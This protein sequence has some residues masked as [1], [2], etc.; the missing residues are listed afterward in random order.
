MLEKSE[1]AKR[2][3]ETQLNLCK[4]MAKWAADLVGQ[5][6]LHSE[7]KLRELGH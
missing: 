6:E 4:R 3:L 2:G 7:R 1:D 5:G